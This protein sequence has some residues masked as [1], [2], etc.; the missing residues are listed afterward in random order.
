[1]LTLKVV[2]LNHNDEEQTSLFFGDSI[3]HTERPETGMGLVNYPHARY[4]GSVNESSEQV[5]IASQ[6]LIYNA[7]GTLKEKLL[8]LPKSDCYIT[9]GGKT[10]D[11]FCSYFKTI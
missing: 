1:M 5:F 6:V 4:I 9:E 8:I 2:T 7:D 11:S 3:E 10:V